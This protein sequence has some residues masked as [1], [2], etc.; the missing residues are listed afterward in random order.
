MLCLSGNLRWNKG[1]LTWLFWTVLQYVELPTGGQ[2]HL[3]YAGHQLIRTQVRLHKNLSLSEIYSL[4]SNKKGVSCEKKNVFKK[5]PWSSLV[6]Q[7]FKD[8]GLGCCCGSGL[9]PGPETSTCHGRS[10]KTTP[11]HK[12]KTPVL[13]GAWIQHAGLVFRI[14]LTL[15][16]SHLPFPSHVPLASSDHTLSSLN[17]LKH[18]CFLSRYACTWKGRFTESLRFLGSDCKVKSQNLIF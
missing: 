8:P 18:R 17:F 12:Q 2:K 6:A 11:K 1:L 4:N 16:D 5:P 14:S 7:Q 3:K 10:Q 9:I 15:Q 13:I